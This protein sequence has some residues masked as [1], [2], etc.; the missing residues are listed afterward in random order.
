M[1]LGR[2]SR[3][4]ALGVTVLGLVIFGWLVALEFTDP[5]FTVALDADHITYRNAA[6]GFLNGE[7]WFYPE[8][9][10]GRPYEVIQGHIMYPPVALLWLI[11]AAFLPDVLWYGIPLAIIAIVVLH[12]RPSLWGW[13]GIALCLGY[14]WSAPHLLG[15]NPGLWVAAACAVGTIWRP[16]FALVLAKPSVFP[17]ALFG[18][19][20]RGWWVIVALGIAASLAMLPLTLQWFGVV[21]NARGQFSGPLYALRDLGWMLLPVVAWWSGNRRGK[22]CSALAAAPANHT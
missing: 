6:L 2:W 13:A 7:G 16:A 17:F 3:P 10:T 8:Q 5:R 12:H 20:H 9:V 14:P 22:A 15:G 21:L 4:L 18:I 11:P 1:S 19:R